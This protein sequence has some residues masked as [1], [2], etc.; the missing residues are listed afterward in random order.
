VIFLGGTLSMGGMVG[1]VTVFGITLRNSIMLI[2]HYEYLVRDEN[3]PWGQQ[4]ATRGAQERLAP[5][6]MTAL[7]TALGLLPLALAS[8][9]PGNAIEGPMAL[10]I[11]GGL[12]T[13][14]LLNL[15]V[16]PALALRYGRFAGVGKYYGTSS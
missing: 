11:L 15:L 6:L 5:I 13:S 2:A 3:V 8:N 7:V 14:T 16:M 9:A 10:V 4:V 12:A 1:F